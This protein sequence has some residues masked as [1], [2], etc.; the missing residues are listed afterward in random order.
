MVLTLPD[1]A[2]PEH[3]Q[4]VEFINQ[5]LAKLSALPGAM[6]AAETTIVPHT[7]GN[8]NT[9][10]VIQGRPWQNAGEA[11]TADLEIISPNYFHVIGMPSS[12][13]TRVYGR[14]CRRERGSGDCQ[15]KPSAGVLAE[16][17]SIGHGIKFGHLESKLSMGHDCG[18][19]GG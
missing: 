12:R 1:R 19:G 18:S 11:R 15:P 17:K 4:K 8:A 13:G 16:R 7:I 9:D 3:A 5:S 2:Y 14:R 6:E 10:F